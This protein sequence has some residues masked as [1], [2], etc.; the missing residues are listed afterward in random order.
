MQTTEML[1]LLTQSTGVSG[2]EDQAIACA[3]ELVK[4]LGETY[5]TPLNSLVC[6]VKTAGP[7]KPHIMLNAHIDEIGMIVTRIDKKGFLKVSQV[8]G[9]DRRM[10]LSSPVVVHTDNGDFRG[11]VGCI[12]PHLQQGERKNPTLNEVY[13]DMGFDS[14]EEAQANI[15]L[16]SIVSFEGP[17][18]YLKN[19]LVCGKAMDDR[20]CCVA[21]IQACKMLKDMDTDCSITLMLSSMEE[22]GGQGAQTAAFG[23]NPTHSIVMDVTFASAPDMSKEKFA[24]LSNGPTISC[25]GAQDNTMFR[26]LLQ[27]AKKHNIPYTLEPSGGNGV[28]GTDAAGIVNRRS[29]IRTSVIGLPLRNMHTPVEV[30]SAQALDHAASLV[31][32]F[33]AEYIR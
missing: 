9:V 4:D 30:I 16:G 27:T 7:D 29:G 25:G 23:V 15:P 31:A 26:Q 3:K 6:K 21:M 2:A 8:G 22:T 12:P 1:Q 19:G 20:C 33:V 17:M 14:Q 18:T 28:S 11:V 32:N 5:V 13:L 10:I 24:E